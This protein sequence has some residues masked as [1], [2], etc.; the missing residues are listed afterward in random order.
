MVCLAVCF[1]IGGRLSASTTLAANVPIATILTDRTRS[2]RL[3]SGGQH[4]CGCVSKIYHKS[5]DPERAHDNTKI[6]FGRGE[7]L[8]V[9]FSA[10]RFQ[11]H[12]TEASTHCN[13]YVRVI[14]ANRKTHDRNASANAGPA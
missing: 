5:V 8:I 2:P 3:S 12:A 1:I 10:T 6:G 7:S 9:V 4:S 13:M 11:M 14:C